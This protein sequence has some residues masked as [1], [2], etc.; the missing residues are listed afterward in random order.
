VLLA[1]IEAQGGLDA[2]GQRINQIQTQC[3]TV[4]PT[5]IIVQAG[6]QTLVQSVQPGGQLELMP[7]PPPGAIYSPPPAAVVEA[8]ESGDPG[9]LLLWTQ[10]WAPSEM[11]PA[12]RAALGSAAPVAG[13]YSYALRAGVPRIFKTQTLPE[14]AEVTEDEC[15]ECFAVE[16]EKLFDALIEA[17]SVRVIKKTTEIF[18]RQVQT[19]IKFAP[20]SPQEIQRRAQ[21]ALIDCIFSPKELRRALSRKLHMLLAAR[22]F[23][24]ADDEERLNECLDRL[25][26]EHPELIRNAQKAALAAKAEVRDAAELPTSVESATVLAPAQRNVYGIFPA[27]LNTWERPFAEMLDADG[28]NTVLWWHRNEPHKPWSINV[29]MESGRGF[30]PDFVVGIKDRP[31]EQNGLLADTKYAYETTRE[32]PKLL[33]EHAAYGRVLIITQDGNKRWG[34]AEFDA[35]TGR[36]RIGRPFRLTEAAGY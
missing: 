17:K 29:L 20:P 28:T 16:A 36:G 3:A 11:K 1:D 13:R 34:V 33:A 12:L 22:G 35:Q 14:E 23:E 32:L 21:R 31:C 27:G 18:S 4:S 9:Q 26:S 19:E 15:A 2:A 6:G 24:D 25:L 5:T 30:F 10:T 7:T 8:V